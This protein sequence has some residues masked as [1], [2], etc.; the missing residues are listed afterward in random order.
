MERRN[1]APTRPPGRGWTADLVAESNRIQQMNVV[2][3]RL[4]EGRVAAL[5]YPV[6]LPIVDNHGAALLFSIVEVC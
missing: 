1:D 2:H 6:R 4:C 3:S 5:L